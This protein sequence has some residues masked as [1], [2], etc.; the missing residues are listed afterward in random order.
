MPLQSSLDNTRVLIIHQIRDIWKRK[1]LSIYLGVL[2]K[3]NTSF[4]VSFVTLLTFLCM[5]PCWAFL[6]LCYGQWPLDQPFNVFTEPNVSGVWVTFSQ[7]QVQRL[8]SICAENWRRPK[9]NFQFFPQTLLNISAI[10]TFPVAGQEVRF[11]NRIT[12]RWSHA[13]NFTLQHW[14]HLTDEKFQGFSTTKKG[15]F[16]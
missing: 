15:S 7:F 9:I 1:R 3:I 4:C 13:G 12:R 14:I 2:D 5:W 10:K 8:G 6:T 16:G 11:W